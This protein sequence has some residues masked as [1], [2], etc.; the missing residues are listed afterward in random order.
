MQDFLERDG[1]HGDHRLHIQCGMDLCEGE[2][3][4]HSQLQ[5]F[6]L[7]CTGLLQL[8]EVCPA[9]VV[10]GCLVVRLSSFSRPCSCVPWPV[11][12]THSLTGDR[13]FVG[14]DHRDLTALA[15]VLLSPPVLLILVDPAAVEE[16]GSVVTWGKIQKIPEFFEEH[17]NSEAFNGCTAP[18]SRGETSDHEVSDGF[19]CEFKQILVGLSRRL[20]VGAFFSQRCVGFQATGMALLAGQ[21]DSHR[22][23]RS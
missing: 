18:S 9:H 8:P 14:G 6:R 19:S 16:D 2:H 22:E 17:I 21:P 7:V 23:Q 3:H 13:F 15:C 11:S 1:C 20:I 10:S 12:C 4:P 5:L